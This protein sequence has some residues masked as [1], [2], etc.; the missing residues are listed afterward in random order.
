MDRRRWT[1]LLIPPKNGSAREYSLPGWSF[2]AAGWAVAVAAVLV[3]GAVTVLFTP[4]GTPGARIV[5]AAGESDRL[6]GVAAAGV[7]DG[8]T[9]LLVLTAVRASPDFALRWCLTFY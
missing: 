5:A 3:L 1:L 8:R 4:W 6:S 9:F 7:L 2:R